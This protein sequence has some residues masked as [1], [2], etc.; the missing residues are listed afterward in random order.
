M[1]RGVVEGCSC[2]IFAKWGKW[3]IDPVTIWL[4][5]LLLRYLCNYLSISLFFYLSV[6]PCIYLPFYLSV[7]LSFC[8]S[9]SSSL[10]S[11]KNATSFATSAAMAQRAARWK[12]TEKSHAKRAARTAGQKK[13]CTIL[14]VCRS[15][16]NCRCVCPL[17]F[18]VGYFW[19][20]YSRCANIVVSVVIWNVFMWH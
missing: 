8:I 9:K 2:D 20:C 3:L 10:D 7:Y 17:D 12:W 18:Q 19:M 5:D 13:W 15:D 11:Q 16:F 14:V 4:T 6:Y 1:T